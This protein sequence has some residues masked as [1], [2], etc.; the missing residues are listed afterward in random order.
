MPLLD[1]SLVTTTLT[2]LL[3]RYVPLSPVWDG[4]PP[5]TIRITGD[6]PD[7]LAKLSEDYK[8]SLYLYHVEEESSRKNLPAP[9][10][11]TPP[12]RYR[13]MGLNLYYVLT[14]HG[15]E[16]TDPYVRE[17]RLIGIALK[18]FHDFPILTANTQIGTGPDPFVFPPALR[19][20]SDKLRLVL[21]PVTMEDLNKLWTAT[22]VALRLSTVYQVS[23]VLLEAERVTVQP[24]PV[25]VPQIEVF[26]FQPVWIHA[27]ESDVTFTLPGE[28]V[29]RSMTHSPALVAV[30]ESFRIRGFGFSGGAV[31]VFLQ[32]PFWSAPPHVEVTGWITGTPADTQLEL[33]VAS[34]VSG[35]DI[36]PG[37]YQVYVRNGR[38]TSNFSPV[39][40][41]PTIAPQTATPP[42]ISPASGPVG[43]T[44][45]VNGGPFSGTDIRTVEIYI[46]SVS[47]GQVTTTPGPGAFRV[48]TDTQIEAA[49][50]S[51][52]PVGP[53]PLR[54]VVNGIGTP[55]MRW[56][57]ITP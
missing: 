50:P 8:L 33:Q 39:A 34:P 20:G 2:R 57:E 21:R 22:T 27:T 23:V 46:G 4:A 48:V 36:V 54:V 56:F 55:P 24:V 40:I 37:L 6:P 38:A 51:T 11:N 10:G 28:T 16:Q 1:L 17:Q 26:P 41:A 32:S 45:T 7:L 29:S 5:T 31:Q 25:L 42:G 3:D 35:R 52:L 14:A 47:L 53:H 19:R 43:T 15:G 9:P 30:G 12:V 18:A 13:E 44:I 49:V